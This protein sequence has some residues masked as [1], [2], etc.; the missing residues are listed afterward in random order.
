MDHLIL[1][2]YE[3]VLR[4]RIDDAQTASM[5][6]AL[7]A[8]LEPAGQTLPSITC[9]KCNCPLLRDGSC[10]RGAQSA[11]LCFA[12]TISGLRALAFN[13]VPNAVYIPC[14]KVR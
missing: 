3:L 12:I 1:A 4:G 9:R 10:G 2:D 7:D 8:D 11:K 5:R 14:Y 13:D 6:A